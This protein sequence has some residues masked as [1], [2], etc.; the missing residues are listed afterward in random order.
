[1][2]TWC[3]LPLTVHEPCVLLELQCIWL[4]AGYLELLCASSK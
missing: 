2:H 4:H 1:M 3:V